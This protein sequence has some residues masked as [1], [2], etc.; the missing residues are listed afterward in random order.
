[1]Y[2]TGKEREI[3]LHSLSEN[4]IHMLQVIYLICAHP[5]ISYL[6]FI[7]H[8]T[9]LAASFAVHA[10]TGQE[11]EQHDNGHTYY[12]QKSSGIHTWEN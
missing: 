3:L 5:F 7:S 12:C 2:T 10:K 11:D 9:W 6:I 4:L 8:L 1:M